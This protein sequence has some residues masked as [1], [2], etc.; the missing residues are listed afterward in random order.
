MRIINGSESFQPNVET[1]TYPNGRVYLSGGIQFAEDNGASWR[2]MVSE[3]LKQMGYYPIDVL[4]YDG[5]F[6][7]KYGSAYDYEA[8]KKLPHNEMKKAVRAHHIDPD[9]DLVAHNTDLLFVVYDEAAQKG[10][11]TQAECQHAYNCGVPIVLVDHLHD[12]EISLWLQAL[13]TVMFK[14]VS[15]A[16][17]YLATLPPQ[18]LIRR[19]GYNPTLNMLTGEVTL[20]E[21]DRYKFLT[22]TNK[23]L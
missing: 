8:M 23:E 16:L 12:G 3:S 6:R 10:C 19:P 18:V 14:S 1:E 4:K 5:M 20:P 13:S 9:M 2:L 7:D 11:G 15:T 17:H 21:V 22:D